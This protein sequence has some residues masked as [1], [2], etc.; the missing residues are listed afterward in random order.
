MRLDGFDSLQIVIVRGVLQRQHFVEL[1]VVFLLK[2]SSIFTSDFAGLVVAAIFC[3]LV[4]EEKREH[5]DALSE[6][7]LLLVKVRLDRFAN[8][9]AAERRFVHVAGGFAGS[10]HHAVG[11]ADRVLD[12]VNI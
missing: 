5:L 11:E 3:D 12:R 2:H 1:G 10:K 8:L 7:R 6:E 4:D 9:D